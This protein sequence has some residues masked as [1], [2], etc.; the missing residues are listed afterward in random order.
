MSFETNKTFSLK[1]PGTAKTSLW[2]KNTLEELPPKIKVHS[3]A[4]ITSAVLV[5]GQ[6]K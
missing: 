4:I 1:D 2:K 6:S 3:K 5:Q